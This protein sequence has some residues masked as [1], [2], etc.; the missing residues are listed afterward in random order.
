MIVDM[1]YV[2]LFLA[3]VLVMGSGLLI[4]IRYLERWGYDDAENHGDGMDV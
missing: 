1:I 2:F 4:A 3:G